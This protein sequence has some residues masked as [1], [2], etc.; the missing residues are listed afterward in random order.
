MEREGGRNRFC[1]LIQAVADDELLWKDKKKRERRKEIREK[2]NK[3]TIRREDWN[4]KGKTSKEQQNRGIDVLQRDF[5][6]KKKAC[7]L[8]LSNP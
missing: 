7:G 4:I 2:C 3:Y 5:T 1:E 8:V 6:S